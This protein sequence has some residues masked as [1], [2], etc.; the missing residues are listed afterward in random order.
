M[1]AL[2]LAP[3]PFL[4]KWFFFGGEAADFEFLALLWILLGAV[5]LYQ[6]FQRGYVL[7]V[8]TSSGRQRLE[9]DKRVNLRELEEFIHQVESSLGYSIDWSGFQH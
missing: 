4:I 8:E 9:F 7:D 5:S 3:V 6:V 2:G 1:L